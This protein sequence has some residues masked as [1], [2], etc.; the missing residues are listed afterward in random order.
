MPGLV[1]IDTLPAKHIDN[2]RL[3]ISGN[4][5]YSPLQKEL[6]NFLLDNKEEF[7]LILDSPNITDQT[8]HSFKSSS[9]YYDLIKKQI[10]EN[11][12]YAVTFDMK[13]VSDEMLKS[14]LVHL[15]TKF[16]YHAV[17]LFSDILLILSS[18]SQDS[19]KLNADS[20]KKIEPLYSEK[21]ESGKI[22]YNDIHC[23]NNI[24]YSEL[25]PFINLLTNSRRLLNENG[26]MILPPELLDY[27]LKYIPDWYKYFIS[28]ADQRFYSDIKSSIQRNARIFS[29][30]K[31]FEYAESVNEYNEEIQNLFELKKYAPYND[32][33]KNYV[34]DQLS[35]KDK[36]YQSEALRLEKSKKWDEA[37]KLYQAI[38]TIDTDNF[39]G[40]YKLGLLYITLQDMNS[41]FTYLDKAL[42]LQKD[43]PQVL[44]QMGTLI[45]FN[46]KFK[47]AIDYLE[48]ANKLNI[49]T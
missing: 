24:L 26:Y 28:D 22:F 5:L 18:D 10:S 14:S 11:G 15:N 8:I 13:F 3:P 12:I 27:Y 45:F 40:N 16:R 38:L 29:I 43:N 36:Y 49:N 2:N 4:Q 6:L 21:T 39:E 41:A 9:E 47:E 37:A 46:D 25:E 20:F 35:F 1:C 48:Q 7:Y 31:N 42:K 33:I 23:L 34:S 30:L 44:Y 32:S 17:Y 19:L